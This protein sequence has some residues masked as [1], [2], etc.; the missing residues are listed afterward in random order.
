MSEAKELSNK[1]GILLFDGVC[2]FCDATVQF[3]HKHDKQD[4][5]RFA[6]LQSE[7]GAKLQKEFGL[8]NTD[9][10]I[11]I[12]QGRAYTRSTAGLRI[13]RKLSGVWS[14]LYAFIVVPRFIRNFA[15]D[16]FSHN[17]YRMFGKKDACTLPTPE[18]RKRFIDL[19]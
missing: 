18:L 4:Y 17:R 10:V 14:L 2:H 13:A 1:H 3:I 11:L 8:Q 9:S 5:F 6:P 7:I 12:E 19:C 15:Y 16:V